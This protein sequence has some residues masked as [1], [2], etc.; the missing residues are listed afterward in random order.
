MSGLASGTLTTSVGEIELRR[1]GEAGQVPLVYLHSAQGE[2]EGMVLLETLCE[3][4][5]VLAPVFCG[6]GT[7]EGIEHVDDIEDAAFWVLDVT[8]RLGASE[9]DLVGMSLG[10]WMAAEFAVRWPEIVRRLV[11]INPVG[12]YV[13]GAPI[14]EIFG[15]N[16]SELAG[17]LFADPDHP[18]AQLMRALAQFDSDPSQIPFDLIRP[19]LQAQAATAKMGWNPYLHNPKLRRRLHRISASTLVIHG[20]QD[21]IV[22][23]VHAE[24]YVEA[25][26]GSRLE[27]LD[28]AAHLAALERPEEIARLVLD[29]LE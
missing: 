15:R 16:L 27:V 17:E 24:A 6:F 25:I 28:Q 12:L 13:E 18:I 26:A 2:G 29:H 20:S 22:P 7:S 21:G 11:L 9:V 1:G 8:E 14:K 19:V 3:S 5:E 23:R 10:G 4:R